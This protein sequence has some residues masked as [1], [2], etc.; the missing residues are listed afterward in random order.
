MACIFIIDVWNITIHLIS[1]M[2]HSVSFNL[3][4]GKPLYNLAIA[5]PWMTVYY[6]SNTFMSDQCLIDI[7]LMVFAT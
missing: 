2:L 6:A 4:E 1:N 3:V 5:D 7:I